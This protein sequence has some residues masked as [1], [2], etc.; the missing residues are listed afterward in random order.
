[1]F[2]ALREDNFLRYKLFLH[3][4]ATAIQCD[5][6]PS[7]EHLLC[8]DFNP[9]NPVIRGLI[10]QKLQYLIMLLFVVSKCTCESN[11]CL[12]INKVKFVDDAQLRENSIHNSLR[13]TAPD[14]YGHRTTARIYVR[15]F[16]Q[17]S[18]TV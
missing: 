8:T 2:S 9:V 16:Q 7:N 18:F 17:Q 1:M 14:I 13:E 4:L 12:F 5:H 15:N 3:R 11:Y 6:E 10:S